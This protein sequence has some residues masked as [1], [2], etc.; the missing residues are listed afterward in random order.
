MI[1]V[2]RTADWQRQVGI[3]ALAVPLLYDKRERFVIVMQNCLN[4]CTQLEAVT[5]IEAAVDVSIA[6]R[7]LPYLQR[8]I[9]LPLPCRLPKQ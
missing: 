7:A 9:C 3:G 1:K 8:R 6:D 5:V 2:Y 4:M